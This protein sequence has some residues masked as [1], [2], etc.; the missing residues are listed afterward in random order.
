MLV[1]SDGK[2]GQTCGCTFG[3]FPPDVLFEAVAPLGRHVELVPVDARVHA[4][5]LEHEA[6]H[7]E[8]L[9]RAPLHHKL[10]VGHRREPHERADFLVVAPHLVVDAAQLGHAADLEGV[11]PDAVDTRT[12]L[13]EHHRE[14]LDVRLARGVPDD[15]AARDEHRAEQRVLGRGDRRLVQQD[16]RAG[17]LLCLEPEAPAVV[18]ERRT[19]FLEREPVRVRPPAADDVPAGWPEGHLLEPREHRAGEQERGP[20]LARQLRIYRRPVHVRGADLHGMR[21]DPF[22]RGAEPAQDLEHPVHVSDPWQVP[23]DHGVAREQ[24]RGDERQGRVLVPH[25]GDL[26]AQRGPAFHDEARHRRVA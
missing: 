12:H 17:E 9:R 16:V 22:H 24:A 2:P 20:H 3:I 18:R 6:D 5:P 4:E 11:R 21:I 13:H 7:R 25:R 10:A 14:L 8:V 23:Q 19:E 26:S 1:R 15:G